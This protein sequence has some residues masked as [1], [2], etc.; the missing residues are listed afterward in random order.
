[1]SGNT[2]QLPERSPET[3]IKHIIND[4][5]HAGN[6]K[7]VNRVGLKE[8]N[9]FGLYDIFGN[10]GE[11][12]SIIEYGSYP[13]PPGLKL[14]DLRDFFP[15]LFLLWMQQKCILK[16]FQLDIEEPSS[17]MGFAA[18]RMLSDNEPENEVTNS[19]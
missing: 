7:K 9:H 5:W 10:V 13:L 14:E 3:V 11:Y 19:I 17:C 4:N 2:Q 15:S 1:M 6:T 12:V 16:Y 18:Q 8:P